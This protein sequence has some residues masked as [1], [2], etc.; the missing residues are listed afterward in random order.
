MPDQ[1]A[2]GPQHPLPAAGPPSGKRRSRTLV[3]RLSRGPAVSEARLAMPRGH[4][5]RGGG[6]LLF[7]PFPGAFVSLACRPR[8]RAAHALPRKCPIH[9]GELLH[10]APEREALTHS[11]PACT[12]LGVCPLG[13]R[14]KR[15][16]RGGQRLRV[17]GGDQ[18]AC[19]PVNDHLAQGRQVASHDRQPGA[20]RL[21]RGVGEALPTR[22]KHEELCSR[23]TPLDILPVPQ[24]PDALRIGPWWALG[25]P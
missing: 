7:R 12:P 23:V 22:G 20:H 3:F 4:P 6:P 11:R 17:I 16:E 24:Q 18:E 5:S 25:E 10:L 14:Q 13:V 2:L 19:L 8:A 15:R 21:Q 1:T 9:Q